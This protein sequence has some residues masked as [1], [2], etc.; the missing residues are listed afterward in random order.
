MGLHKL[1]A[2]FVCLV[3]S[4]D[5]MGHPPMLLLQTLDFTFF[6]DVVEAQTFHVGN[7]Q[8]FNSQVNTDG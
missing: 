2:I 6:V 8:F 1:L 5:F 3:F 4:T 7:S